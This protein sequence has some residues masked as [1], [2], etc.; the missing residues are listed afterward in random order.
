MHLI[1][2]VCCYSLENI[3]SSNTGIPYRDSMN[4]KKKKKKMKK[5]K[6]QSQRDTNKMPWKTMHRSRKANSKQTHIPTTDLKPTRTMN[7]TNKI[8][9]QTKRKATT[10]KSCKEHLEFK[11][12][13]SSNERVCISLLHCLVATHSHRAAVAAGAAAFTATHAYVRWAHIVAG[14]FFC[15]CCCCCYL[16]FVYLPFVCLFF[17]VEPATDTN[18]CR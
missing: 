13:A 3:K 18:S 2:C 17:F 4:K 7:H 11:F 12:S 10:W 15:C 8:E 14:S 1:L 5:E 6:T 9:C 16:M